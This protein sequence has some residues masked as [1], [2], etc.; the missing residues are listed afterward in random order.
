MNKIKSIGYVAGSKLAAFVMGITRGFLVPGYL[1]PQLYGVIGLLKLVKIILGFT[2]FGMDQ[3]YFRLSLEYGGSDR[4]ESRKKALEDNVF[5]FL[6]C[7]ALIG[8]ILTV[9][10]PFILKTSD[11]GLQKIMIFCFA[12]TGVQHF[13]QFTG[14]FFFKTM[15]IK[16]E[17]RFISLMNIVQ[18]L[19]ALILILAMVFRWKIYAV[20]IAD[21]VAVA[22]V[23]ILYFRNAGIMPELRI[24]LSEFRK[25]FRYALPFFIAGICFYLFRFTDRT[26]IASFLTLRELGLYTFA[27]GIAENT[28]MLSVAIDEVFS[29]FMVE[30]IS[31]AD[32]LRSL[33]GEITSYTYTL[34][35]IT[36]AVSLL[37]V[38]F[39]PFIKLILP[40]YADALLVLKILLIN[41]IPRTFILYQILL[42]SSPRVNRQNHINIAMTVSGIINVVL[43]IFL[44][45]R[46]YG[47]T[48]V[49]AATFLSQIL[50]AAFYLIT[51][52]KYYLAGKK[53]VFY[54]KISVTMAIMIIYCYLQRMDAAVTLK[55]FTH[56]SVAFLALTGALAFIFKKEIT[57][58]ISKFKE[59]MISTEKSGEEVT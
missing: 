11:A 46:G 1:G 29:P 42:L 45:K 37:S 16:K 23:Q 15:H 5:T 20:F 26:V 36:T 39:C 25:T 38:F 48:G 19:I 59:K 40:K 21:L 18:P 34:L 43:S 12:V 32:N 58:I 56:D 8:M 35:F 7:S 13:F 28:R 24:H 55:N 44:I 49:V 54:F 52:G 57:G 27:I 3:A 41:I 9:L 47:I 2:A 10:L 33:S 30:K 6:F 14:N 22:A 31:K 17:F 50:M 53:T 4:D 51:S